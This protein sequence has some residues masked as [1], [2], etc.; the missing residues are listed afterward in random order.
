M[1]DIK[2][3]DMTISDEDGDEFE[4]SDDHTNSNEVY[5]CP[6]CLTDFT[7]DDYC[8]SEGD[9]AKAN[10][11]GCGKEFAFH[12]ESVTVFKSGLVE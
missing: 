9:I 2:E 4:C 5:C 11:P 8:M 7:A 6:H 12:Y 1:V 3:A 10:C